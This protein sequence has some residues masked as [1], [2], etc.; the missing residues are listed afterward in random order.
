MDFIGLTKGNGSVTLKYLRGKILEA[1]VQIEPKMSKI[2]K[3]ETQFI[4][5]T[6]K[7]TASEHLD[8]S[9]DLETEPEKTIAELIEEDEE[10]EASDKQE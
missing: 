5:S 10:K 6:L 4:S 1:A 3:D 9:K 2:M 8:I 7:V